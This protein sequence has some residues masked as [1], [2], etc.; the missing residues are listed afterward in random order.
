MRG[1][2]RRPGAAAAWGGASSHRYRHRLHIMIHIIQ[3][4]IIMIIIIIIMI[5]RLSGEGKLPRH[6]CRHRLHRYFAQRVPSICLAS[7]FRNC[8]NCA[9]LKCTFPWRTTYP[10]S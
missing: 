8:L 1:A 10:L 9:V 6:V 3:I 5:I 4:M 7:S 2:D